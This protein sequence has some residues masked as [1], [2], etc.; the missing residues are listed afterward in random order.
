MASRKAE[1]ERLRQE[2]LAREREQASASRRRRMLQFYGLGGAAVAVAAVI[3]VVVVLGGSGTGP[4][5]SS[6]APPPKVSTA[7]LSAAG[8]VH[9]APAAGPLGPEG[10]PIPHVPQ[11]ASN[12]SIA[13]GQTV[14]GIQC[15]AGEKLAYH[16]HTHLTVFVNGFQRQIP[17][18]IGIVPPRQLENTSA[19]PFVAGGSCFYWLHT[20]ADDGIIHIESPTFKTYSLGQFFAIWRQPLGPDQVGPAK[21]KVTA[22]YNGKLYKGNPQNIPLGSHYQVQLDVGTPLIAPEKVSFAGTGL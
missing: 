2:R 19:G 3:V 9:P 5:G 4:A 11:L 14:D 16:V 6:S 21:G 1:K 10:I 12:A 20:H 8:D 13:T 18:G 22:F 15:N 7:P 17:Y